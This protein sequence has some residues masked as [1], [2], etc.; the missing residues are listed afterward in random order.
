MHMTVAH[1]V[2]LSHNPGPALDVL[3]CGRMCMCACMANLT[4]R[5]TF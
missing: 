4:M 3:A 1:P 2:N 5:D